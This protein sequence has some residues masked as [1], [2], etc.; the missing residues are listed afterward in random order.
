[1]TSKGLVRK[2]DTESA[3]LAITTVPKAPGCAWTHARTHIRTHTRK[4]IKTHVRTHKTHY[5]NI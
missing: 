4:Y 5:K 2:P 1:M 3:R